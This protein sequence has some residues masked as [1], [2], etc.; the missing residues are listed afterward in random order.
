MR[1]V[2][3]KVKSQQSTLY[4]RDR[5]TREHLIEVFDAR[6]FQCASMLQLCSCR[7][8]IY[9]LASA[10]S[11][12]PFQQTA[13]SMEAIQLETKSGRELAVT[14]PL[15]WLRDLFLNVSWEEINKEYST[16][17]RE[18]RTIRVHKSSLTQIQSVHKIIHTYEHSRQL[19]VTRERENGKRH[20]KA[21]WSKE[22]STKGYPS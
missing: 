10:R 1:C 7:P 15:P 9:S 2:L 8:L 13:Q 20:G 11:V 16:K 21:S 18:N 12:S 17:T 6:E 22:L 5:C 3:I 19:G 14:S 4:H